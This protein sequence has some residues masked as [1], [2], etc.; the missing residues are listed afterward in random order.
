MEVYFGIG[1]KLLVGLI[2]AILL[3]RIIGRKELAQTTPLDLIFIMMLAEIIGGMAHDQDYDVTHVIFTI[4]IWGFYVWI[5]ELITKH[6]KI[7]RWVKGKPEVLIKDGAV[8]TDLMEREN[9]TM[10]ELQ[11]QLREQGVFDIRKVRIAVLEISGKISIKK[12]RD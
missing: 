11:T 12:R 10:E 5:S 7:E 4:F 3:I 6:K 1:V 2:C 9:L 8:N